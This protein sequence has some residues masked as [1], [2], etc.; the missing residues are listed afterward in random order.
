[1]AEKKPD[2]KHL[3]NSNMECAYSKSC[4]ECPLDDCRANISVPNINMLP[5][6]M[7]YNTKKEKQ[8]I[9]LAQVEQS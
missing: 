5:Y 6:D 8:L 9:Q 7:E 3:K 1:M 2:K 4:F